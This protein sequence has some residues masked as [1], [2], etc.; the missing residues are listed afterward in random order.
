HFG[1]GSGSSLVDGSLP[2]RYY[3]IGTG[4]VCIFDYLLGWIPA[5][6][7]KHWS[8]RIMSLYIDVKESVHE[9]ARPCSKVVVRVVHIKANRQAPR[10]G[11]RQ[12]LRRGNMKNIEARV[13]S[14]GQVRSAQ[15]GFG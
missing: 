10:F 11:G 8:W 9:L 1:K 14:P 6:Q 4:L 5:R 2:G 7:M 13:F 12:T 15:D 3:E